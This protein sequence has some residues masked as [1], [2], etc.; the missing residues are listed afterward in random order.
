MEYKR[1]KPKP[2]ECDK[3]QLC[4][5][6]LCLEEMLATPVPAGAIFY[7]QPRRRLDV[8]LDD[9]LRAETERAAERLHDLIRAGRTPPAEYAARNAAS[10]A[11]NTS[12]IK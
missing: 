5:Q 11:W 8:T 1:G 12:A 6:A 3:V 9:A 7:G 2:D 4:A 10:S